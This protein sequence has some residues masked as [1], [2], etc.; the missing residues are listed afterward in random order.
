MID[1]FSGTLD[2]T[3]KQAALEHTPTH[4]HTT[5]TRTLRSEQWI[6]TSQS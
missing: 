4:T 1:V 5:S 2:A 6:P 3:E